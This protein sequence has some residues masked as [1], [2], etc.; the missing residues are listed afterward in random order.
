LSA[1]SRDF[2]HLQNPHPEIIPMRNSPEIEGLGAI[3]HGTTAAGYAAI[4]AGGGAV[5]AGHLLGGPYNDARGNRFESIHHRVGLAIV[6]GVVA[7]SI[8]A[9]GVHGLATAAHARDA[10]GVE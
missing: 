3:S 7:W 4:V 1:T 2:S 5:I 9:I 8:Y 10:R 6:V